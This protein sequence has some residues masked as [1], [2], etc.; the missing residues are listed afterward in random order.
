MNSKKLYNIALVAVPSFY[1]QV[2]H[3][4]NK[5]NLPAPFGPRLNPPPYIKI[6]NPSEYMVKKRKRTKVYNFNKTG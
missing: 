2:L 1:V 4:M 3:L 5:M 6:E